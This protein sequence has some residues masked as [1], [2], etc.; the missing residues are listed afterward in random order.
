MFKDGMGQQAQPRR[1]IR[2]ETKPGNSSEYFIFLKLNL[3][4]IFH[5]ESEEPARKL[6]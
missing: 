5:V 4:Y 1:M 2:S 6:M 3:V